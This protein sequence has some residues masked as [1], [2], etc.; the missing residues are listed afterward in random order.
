MVFQTILKK[1]QQLPQNT[2]VFLGTS[3]I[4]GVSAIPFLNSGDEKKGH[5]LFS[6]ERPEVIDEEIDRKR[7]E[8][9][10]SK[11]SKVN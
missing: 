8:Y 10:E 7:R 1:V 2:Q 11:R 9:I 5:S 6:Q 4:L 3:I